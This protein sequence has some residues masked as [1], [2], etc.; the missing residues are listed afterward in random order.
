MSTAEHGPGHDKRPRAECTYRACFRYTMCLLIFIFSIMTLLMCLCAIP[1][2]NFTVNDVKFYAFNLSRETST[3]TSNLQIT[4]SSSN[5][6]ST[7]IHFDQL[8]LYVSYRNQH[9]TLPISFPPMYLGST[10]VAVWSPYLNGTD[11]P[12]TADLVEYLAEDKT[13]TMLINKANCR[14]YIM[15][16]NNNGSNVV[17]SSVKNPF[18]NDTCDVDVV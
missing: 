7:G 18:D 2:P 11:V 15:F 17:G 9:I 16:Q 8:S 5:H 10:D 1:D 3:L 6:D 12:L 4:I 13:G 14:A